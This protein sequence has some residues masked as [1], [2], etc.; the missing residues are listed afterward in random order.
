LAFLY[1]DVSDDMGGGYLSGEF[2]LLRD[3]RL[4]RR[5]TSS[6]SSPRTTTWRAGPWALDPLWKPAADLDKLVA[7]LTGRGFA[8]Y[9]PS[10][11]PVEASEAGPFPGMP[12]AAG[13]ALY[14]A[15]RTGR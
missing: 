5:T 12:P 2:L 13:K 7:H 4:F 3:G 11:V 1:E 15:R 10:P 6:S 14:P 8:L 9:P